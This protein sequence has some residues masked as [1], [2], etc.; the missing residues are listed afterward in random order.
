MSKKPNNYYFLFGHF[1]IRA[2]AFYRLNLFDVYWA[3]LRHACGKGVELCPV[4]APTAG[5]SFWAR[6]R[7]ATTHLDRHGTAFWI[8]TEPDLSRTT[9]RLAN[10]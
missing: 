6:H 10:E 9:I 8:V 7:Y 4:D 3:L 5:L 2:N 1:V